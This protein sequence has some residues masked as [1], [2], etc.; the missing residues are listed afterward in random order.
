MSLSERMLGVYNSVFSFECLNKNLLKKKRFTQ[1]L[2]SVLLRNQR[3]LEKLFLAHFYVKENSFGSE[4]PILH[5]RS[6]II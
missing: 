5:M 4:P 3:I 1:D 6:Q 2:T